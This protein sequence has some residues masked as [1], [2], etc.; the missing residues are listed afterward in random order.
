MLK[1]FKKNKNYK[2]LIGFILGLLL[3]GGSTYASIRYSANMFFYNNNTSTLNSNDVQGA[4]HELATKYAVLSNCPN[5]KLCLQRKSTLS[6]GDYVSYT[7]T[8]G[9]YSV[10]LTKTGGTTAQSI[11]PSE[12]DLWR[13]ISVNSNG[14]ADIISENVSS[15]LITFRQLVGYKNLVGYLNV[16]ASQYET[17]GITVGS[18]HFGFNGQTEYITDDTYFTITTPWRCSTNGISGDC[19]VDSTLDPDD[20][21][22]F[23]GGDLLYLNDYNLVYN[24]LGTSI[25]YKKNAVVSSNYWISSRNYYVSHN[26]YYQ[27]SEQGFSFSGNYVTVGGSIWTSS[28]ANG[29][30][31]KY[32]AGSTIYQSFNSAAVRPIVTLSSSL[33]Y[34]GVGNKDFPMRIIG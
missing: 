24:A 13:V 9:G 12:L 16:L 31:Y 26:N 23:G 22:S 7:P 19:E 4:I 10:D 14:T 18:R 3:F 11:N 17:P 5:D 25:A 27:L 21:E 32:T 2:L 28:S 34:L 6:P 30:Y 1:M 33:T 15:S 20:F 29:M 8:N